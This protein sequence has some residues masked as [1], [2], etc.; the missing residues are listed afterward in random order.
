MMILRNLVLILSSLSIVSCS[1]LPGVEDLEKVLPDKRTAYQKSKGMATLEVPPDLTVT[2]GEYSADI[3]GEESTSLSEFE[4]QRSQNKRQG[5][6]LGS[7]E[8]N[9]EQ[10]LALRGSSFDIW[11][12]LKEFWREKEYVIGLDDAEL[13]V[14]ETDWKEDGGSR[15][16]F[17]IF[18]ESDESGGT[19]LFMSSEK[20]DLSEGEWLDALADTR[21][22]KNVIRKLNLH[23][24]GT[25]VPNVASTASSSS[26]STSPAPEVTAKPVK[27]KAEILNVGDGKSY[28]AI[29]QEFTRAWREAQ[30]ILERAGYLIEASDQEKGTYDFRYFM[31]EGEKEEKGLLSKLKFWGDDEDEGTPYQLSLTGVGDKTEV[32]VMNKDGEWSTGA[33]ANVIL[34]ALK[35]NYNKI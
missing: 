13:G 8:E 12:K 31:P 32:I 14:L 16:K 22:E 2:E 26:R 5:S 29:P 18:T 3:P 9:G 34:E 7:G 27:P 4:R 30:M 6:V 17:K 25:E 35:E 20:Q 21:M 23:F 1:Y 28:L 19:I 11:P 24:Y 33:D 15:H 10:W